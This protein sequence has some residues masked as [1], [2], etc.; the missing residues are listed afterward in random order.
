MKNTFQK[1]LTMLIASALLFVSIPAGNLYAVE[2]SADTETVQGQTDQENTEQASET[3]AE[4]NTEQTTETEDETE[5]S[6][7]QQSTADVSEDSVQNDEK[8]TESTDGTELTPSEAEENDTANSWRF[9]NG[10]RILSNG[11]IS[12]FS[13][14][15]IGAWSEN[16]GRFYNDIGEEIDGAA[17]KGIDVSQWNGNIDW[18]KVKNTDVDY[19]MIRCGYG[20]NQTNQDDTMWKKNADACTA[21]GIPFGT[22]LYSYADTVERAKSEAEHVLRLVKGYNLSYP[23][24]YDLEET[25]VRNSVSKAQIAQIAK[26]FCDTIR[27]A[28]YKVGV[29]A[30]LDW[31]NNYLTDPVFDNYERWVAQWNHKCTYGGAYSMWQCTDNGSVDGISGPVDLDFSMVKTYDAEPVKVQDSNIITY[32]THQQTY[33]WDSGKQNGYQSGYT[34]YSKRLEAIEISVGEGYGDLGVKYQVHA[35]SYGWMDPVEN[36]EVAGTTGEA[37]RI[38]AIRIWLTGAEAQKYDIYYRVHSQTYG[39]LD[40]A[41][42]GEPAGTQGYSKRVEAI[43]IA[44][45]PKGSAAPGDTENAYVKMPLTVQYSTYVAGNGWQ[46][47][48]ADGSQNGTTGQAL[49]VE[50]FR[51]QVAN[52]DYDC[53]G[54]IEYEAYMQS[55]GWQDAVKEN[56]AEAGIAGGGKRLEAI[57]MRLTGT[58]KDRYD[59]YYRVYVQTYGWLDWAKDWQSAGTFDYA[60]RVE[61]IQVKLVEKNE[62]GNSQAPGKTAEPSKQA[63]LKYS[64]HVQTYGWRTDSFDGATSGTTGLAKRLEAMRISFADGKNL[65]E[66]RYRTHVQTYGW[67]DWVKGN[68][69][70]GTEGLA[71]RM[72]AVQ[73]ELTGD[74]AKKYDIYY[75]LHVQT[76]GW[77]DWAKNGEKAGT[78]GLSKRAEAIQIQ[79]VEKGEAAPGSTSRPFVKAE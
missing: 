76:Y 45:L 18:A 74:M 79:L 9:K 54:D 36:G 77:L 35:Q 63:L 8:E 73:I 31:F 48:S 38:E 75:R 7:K 40:W 67:Q 78:E 60:K 64:T 59:V 16:N 68:E 11:G 14:R 29:Y 32:S 2:S 6:D 57:R 17:A 43:Q 39:W 41:K 20:M 12:T 34:G 52:L 46:S 23:I 15:A 71:K 69:V 58:L 61:A 21:N 66:I 55:Y 47:V 27:A 37:K 49:A 5:S 25:S 42:N 22:Y 70:S 26:T 51:A 10:E 50:A 4:E 44:V 72:E 53:N 28:G 65:D 13:A 24:Y 56:Y 1:V 3:P 19:A 30:N 33:G 62:E